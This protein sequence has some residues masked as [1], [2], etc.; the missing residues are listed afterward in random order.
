MAP[1]RPTIE[2]IRAS[3]SGSDDRGEACPCILVAL[4]EGRSATID[5][6]IPAI[7]SA[8]RALA[9]ADLYILIEGKAYRL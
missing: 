1:L 8:L 6:R 9:R 3:L 2:P 5:A 7:A 4:P